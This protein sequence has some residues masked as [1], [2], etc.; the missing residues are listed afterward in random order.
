MSLNIITKT[1]TEPPISE[2]EILRYSGCKCADSETLLLLNSCMDEAKRE[3]SYNVCYLELPISINGISCDFGCFSV[4]SA[5][6]SRNLGGC[7]SVIV[8]SATVGVGIDRLISKYT[9]LSPAK[10]LMLQAIGSERVEALC[11]AFCDEL[12]EEKGVILRP[13]CSPGYGDLP[14]S[15]QKDIFRVLESSKRIALSLNDNLIMSP[16][17]SVTAFVG[18]IGDES[19]HSQRGVL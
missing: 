15:I 11:D 1:Y 16:T 10:A 17:K 12:K 18:I 5:Q 4:K 9:R 7:K 19:D 3:L 8:F 2:S 6:L 13:R 14:L